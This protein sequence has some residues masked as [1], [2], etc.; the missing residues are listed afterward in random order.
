MKVTAKGNTVQ[1]NYI[2]IDAAGNAALGNTVYGVYMN[3]ASVNNILNNTISGNTPGGI[4]INGN[5]PYRARPSWYTANGTAN[6]SVGTNNG[7][8][9]G[10]ATYAPGLS[11]QAFSFDGNG[12]YVSIATGTN[13]PIGNSPYSLSAWFYATSY[14]NVLGGVEGIIGYGDYG[15]YD[16][17]RPPSGVRYLSE[18][19]LGFRHYW[20]SDDLDASTS[21][22][23]KADRGLYKVTATYNGTYRLLYLDG[24]LIGQ[25]EPGTH[26]VPNTNNFA[27]GLTAAFYNEYFEG[28]IEQVAIFD[29]AAFSFRNPEYLRSAS[30]RPGRPLIQ[31]NYI[32]TNFAGSVRA[33]AN[34]GD[35]IDVINSV[36]NT[37][38]GTA[39]ASAGNVISGQHQRRYRDHRDRHDRQP[40]GG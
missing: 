11:G 32:G 7:V 14:T 6:D 38:G 40:G 27:I 26:D 13:I 17:E 15:T 19:P 25:D 39:A 28:L 18:Y 24:V 2:G 21:D 9:Q 20:W 31:G 3:N 8:L 29:R 30:R 36:G 34:G 4:R 22:Q 1:N 23:P 37:I 33:I 10:G 16:E 5:G 12:Q 35:G